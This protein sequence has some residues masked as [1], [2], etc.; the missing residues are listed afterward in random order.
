MKNPFIIQG[1][2]LS[3]PNAIVIFNLKMTFTNISR[4]FILSIKDLSMIIMI[5]GTTGS[6]AITSQKDS[7]LGGE[8]VTGNFKAGDMALLGTEV[9]GK[10]IQM[11]EEEETLVSTVSPCIINIHICQKM[12]RRGLGEHPYPLPPSPPP[13][14]SPPPCP[15]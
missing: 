4:I 1:R 8:V 6:M 15:L 9:I 11:V 12:P 14:L 2:I 3:A 13:H 10:D 7:N 5:T